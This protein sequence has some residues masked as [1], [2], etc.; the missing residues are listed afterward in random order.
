NGLADQNPGNDLSTSIFVI[1]KATLNVPFTE[2]FEGGT[3]PPTSWHVLGNAGL[4]EDISP[5]GFGKSSKSSKSNFATIQSGSAFLV[6][7]QIKLGGFSA[8]ITLNFSIAYSPVD[9]VGSYPDSLC[10]SVS[11]D[12]GKTW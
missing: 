7:P 11:D 8:P 2:G 12:C 3:V 10:V 1:S 4:F 6:S 5:G 9:L